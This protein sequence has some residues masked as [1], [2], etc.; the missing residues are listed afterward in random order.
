MPKHTLREIYSAGLLALGATRAEHRDTGKLLAFYR[1]EVDPIH[2]DEGA[3]NYGNK[4]YYFVGASGG[5]RKGR[6]GSD[7]FSL[8]NTQS[9]AIIHAKGVEKLNPV[10]R[11]QGF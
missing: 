11:F 9:E 7:S 10:N 2:P 6:C 5:L 1:N 4:L 3:V 8:Q